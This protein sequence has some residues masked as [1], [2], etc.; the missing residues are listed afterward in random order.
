ML[1]TD[2]SAMAGV[3]LLFFFALYWQFHG[4]E[5]KLKGREN[6]MP[7]GSIS[8]FYGVCENKNRL[9]RGRNAQI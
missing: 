4:K 8:F 1:Q 9:R 3:Y 2:R 5:V 7:R 6:T